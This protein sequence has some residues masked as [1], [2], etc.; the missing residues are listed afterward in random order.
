MIVIERDVTVAAP[1][2][3][4]FDYLADFETT[5]EWDP[6]T[7]RT[8][9]V[10]GA[11]GVGTTYQNISQFSG[12]ETQ[13]TYVVEEFDR[14]GRIVLRGENKTVVARDT[15]TFDGG[16]GST[17]VTYRAE[18]QLKGL[19]RFAEPFLRKAFDRLG[20]EAEEGLR[21]ALGKLAA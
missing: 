9:R 12:R 10:S 6:G 4:V 5:E 16:A 11:G 14:P 1:A 19:A 17:R 18:F 3:R 21:N 20:E 15:M 7:V 13:L 2:E 8:R